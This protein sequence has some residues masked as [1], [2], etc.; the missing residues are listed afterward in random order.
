[1]CLRKLWISRSGQ[2]GLLLLRLLWLRKPIP[3][4]RSLVHLSNEEGR[5][6]GGLCLLQ[7]DLPPKKRLTHPVCKT[8]RGLHSFMSAPIRLFYG[9]VSARVRVRVRRWVCLGML[10]CV[11]VCPFLCVCVR[12]CVCVG[13]GACLWLCG[14]VCACY[15]NYHLTAT[16]L[17][18][19]LSQNVPFCGMCMSVFL[20]CFVFSLSDVLCGA[21]RCFFQC[22]KLSLWGQFSCTE[23]HCV[24]IVS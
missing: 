15:V 24:H 17:R 18:F 5:G 9:L 20:F 1:M 13:G 8:K 14:C 10:V 19:P 21:L 6:Y 22:C 12:L 7:Y 3:E 16:Q 2:F 11:S 23:L 4:R